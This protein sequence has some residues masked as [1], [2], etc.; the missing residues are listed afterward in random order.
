MTASAI[1]SG[2][3]ATFRHVQGR[4][5]LQLVIEVPAESASSVFSTFGYPGSGNPIP[6]AVA[7]LVE[8]PKA[9]PTK[10][11]TPFIDLPLAQQAAMRCNEMGFWF[12]I[13]ER[14]GKC[15]GPDDAARFVRLHCNVSSRAD[16]VEGSTAGERWKA[17]EGEYFAHSR[18]RR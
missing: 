4:K 10:Q 14:G 1:I 2:D 6:V 3:F 12:F 16:I 15:E 11:R 13:R 17:L 7:R 9:E 5:V 18:G 8:Q